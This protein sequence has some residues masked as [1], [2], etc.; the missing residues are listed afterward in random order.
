MIL[1]DSIY[2][3]SS[4]GISLL[5]TFIK[6]IPSHSLNNY[7]FLIDRRLNDDFLKLKKIKNKLVIDASEKNRIKFYFKNKNRFKSFFCFGNVPP[8]ISIDKRVVIYFQNEL[9]LNNKNAHLSQ[10]AQLIL[11]LKKKYIYLLN[12]KKYLWAVQTNRMKEKL[13]ESLGVQSNNVETYPFFE[14]LNKSDK[15]NYEKNTFIYVAGPGAHKNHKK[16]LLGFNEAAK[17]SKVHLTLRLT[18]PEDVFSSLLNSLNKI[19][20]NLRIENLGILKKEKL[21]KSY[22]KSQYC[23]YP[24]LK[25][26]FGLP[27]IEAAQLESSIIASNLP[28]VSEVIKPSLTFDPN[29]EK[30]I[31]LIVLKAVNLNVPE[32]TVLKVTNKIENL[33][34]YI[35]NDI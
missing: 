31:A 7:F 35:S 12:K 19:Y 18:L 34:S 6:F 11:T 24:S 8:P 21:L 30:D 5:N 32:K 2:I 27:L 4:G 25:E 23:I 13:V 22:Q 20:P 10:K 16:L 29:S 9:L 1:V 28:F 15:I 33:L 14:E 26:S 3:N 17:N